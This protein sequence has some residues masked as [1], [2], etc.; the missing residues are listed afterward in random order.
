MTNTYELDKSRLYA[1]YFG[2]DEEQGLPPDED[3]RQIWL[4]YLPESRVLPFGCKDNFWEMGSTGPCGPCTEIHYD[5]EG[6]RDAAN[7]VNADRP[8]CIEIWNVVFI[9]FNRETDGSLK[10][11]PSKHVD[12]GMGLERLTSILQ[13]KIWN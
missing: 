11:L 6:G 8:D 13:D 4:Q 3:A 1:T 9:Q 2:G 10:D 5:R 7:L 12:T